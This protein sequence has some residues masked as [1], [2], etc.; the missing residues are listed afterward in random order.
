MNFC[1]THY[2]NSGKMKIKTKSIPISK[3]F[4]KE[5]YLKEKCAFAQTSFEVQQ[6]GISNDFL[7]CHLSYHSR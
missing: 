1:D 4:D 7:K 6:K 5:C 2:L 3:C